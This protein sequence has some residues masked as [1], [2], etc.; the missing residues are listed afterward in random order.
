MSTEIIEEMDRDHYDL[1]QNY[2]QCFDTDAGK[3]VLEDLKT[4][5]G[6]RLSFQPD[7]YGTAFKEGQRSVYL[8]ILRSIQER[9]E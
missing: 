2:K 7:P 4:A 3:K 6:D 5:Y 8:R 1:I 9:K